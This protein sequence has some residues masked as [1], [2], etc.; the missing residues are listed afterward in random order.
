MMTDEQ[1]KAAA[2]IIAHYG[3][4]AQKDILIEECAE[5]IQATEKSRRGEPAVFTAD[6]VEEMADVQILLMQFI[7][8]FGEHWTAVFEETINGKLKRQAER[9]E[10][11][12]SKR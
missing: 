2:G 11:E 4:E 12:R 3:V 8:L 7:S 6:M 9:I 10:A 5:L 1:M